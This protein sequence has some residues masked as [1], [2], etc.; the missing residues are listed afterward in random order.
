[1]ATAPAAC[2][3]TWAA[4]QK[5]ASLSPFVAAAIKDAKVQ[6]TSKQGWTLRRGFDDIFAH[7]TGGMGR[8]TMVV[9]A[10]GARNGAV[11]SM[12][13]VAKMDPNK[14]WRTQIQ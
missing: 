12:V 5:Y 11:V 6:S 1:V 3:K 9:G 14:G 8:V 2:A 7:G 10:E 13:A 4:T